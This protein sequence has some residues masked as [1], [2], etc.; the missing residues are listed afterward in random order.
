MYK[1]IKLITAL[2]FVCTAVL[3]QQQ[4]VFTRQ[5]FIAQVKAW[6]PVARQANIQMEKAN[7]QLM[8]ARGGFDPTLAFDANRKTFDGKNYYYHTN[9]QLTVP[10]PVGNIKTGIEE[11][12]GA[13]LTPEVT[14]GKTSYLGVELPLAN[15]LLI[16]K[17]RATLRQAKLLINQTEQE[18][19]LALNNLIYEAS[20]AYLQWAAS[21]QQYKLYQQFTNVASNRLRLMRIAYTNGDRAIVDTVEAF[22]Q[23]Q[24]YQ[25]QQ[26]DAALKLNNAGFEL[27]NYLWAEGDKGYQLPEEYLPDT[28][29]FATPANA[30]MAQQLIDE[31][32]GKNPAL[33]VYDY[34]LAGLETERKL[35]QQYLLPYVSIK[36]NLLNKD[37]Y[38]L[39]NIS[40]SFIQN[41]YAWGIDVKMPLFLREARGEYKKAQL[42]IQETNLELL[43]KRQQ[44]D[45]KIRSYVNEF[46]TLGSQLQTAQSMYKNYQL[47]LRSEELK[48]MQGESSLFLVNSRE[49]K[50][51]EIL[52]KQIDLATKMYKAKYAA[53]LAAGVMN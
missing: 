26:A 31:S 34:K 43:N 7:A 48:F 36:A 44:T 4:V 51:I 49:T 12:G 33:K 35:K 40:T 38:A 11:N 29:L 5:D 23:L 18:R 27:S 22:V 50:V 37:Y 41:N 21:Y 45:N 30:L 24:N 52:Q 1:H 14:K 13:N 2:L 32:A 6:H 3:G 10:L 25:L 17:R 47:L 8:A 39:K 46:T 20:T 9:P 28:T 42:K 16:D 15:G 53:E 19:Q